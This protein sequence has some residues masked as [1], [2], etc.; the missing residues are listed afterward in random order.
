LSKVGPETPLPPASASAQRQ[1]QVAA[2]VV[3]PF[4]SLVIEAIPS[5]E[6]KHG[7]V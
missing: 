5:V 2:V 4:G 7:L 1:W 6:L 3:T